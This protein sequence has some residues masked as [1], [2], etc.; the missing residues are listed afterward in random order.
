LATIAVFGNKF[1]YEAKSSKRTVSIFEIGKVPSTVFH[2]LVYDLAY[3]NVPSIRIKSDNEFKTELGKLKSSKDGLLCPNK[4][5]T[6]VT[7]CVCD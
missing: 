1:S 7:E 3:I 4:V 6:T 2:I 5:I